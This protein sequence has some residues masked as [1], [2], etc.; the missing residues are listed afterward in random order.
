M[1]NKPPFDSRE[2]EAICLFLTRLQRGPV[3]A[4]DAWAIGVQ[5][6]KQLCKVFAYFGYAVAA[7]K[8]LVAG[9][10]KVKLE[11]VYVLLASP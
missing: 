5:P 7:Q 2:A 4:A 6:G 1:N 3:S 8:R 9:A 11:T 10:D